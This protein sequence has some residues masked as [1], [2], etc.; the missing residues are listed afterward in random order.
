MLRELGIQVHLHGENGFTYGIL[1][2]QETAGTQLAYAEVDDAF[3]KLAAARRPSGGCAGTPRSSAST[4]S[5]WF[6]GANR[7]RA[8]RCSRSVSAP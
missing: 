6:C 7:R 5:A 1:H 8:S 4:L 2:E 3:R